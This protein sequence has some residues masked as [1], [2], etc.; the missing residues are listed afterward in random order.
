M[1]FTTNEPEVRDPTNTGDQA[2]VLDDFNRANTVE[3]NIGTPQIGAP[4]TLKGPGGVV[5]SSYGRILGNRVNTSSPSPTGSFYMFQYLTRA[6]KLMQCKATFDTAA[7]AGDEPS[8]TLACGPND[9]ATP[10][11]NIIHVR[12]G[13]SW[14]FI[15]TFINN[16]YTVRTS[17]QH[18]P[19]GLAKDT[20]H[21]F[22]VTFDP[23]NNT[24]K[25]YVN[26]T[27]YAT[28][29]NA[30]LAPLFGPQIFYQ[31]TYGQTDPATTL[32]VDDVLV[33]LPPS[34]TGY[35]DLPPDQISV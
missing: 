31:I 6:P 34:A 5:A 22:K 33:Q 4:W 3:P 11:K 1:T 12:F 24:V 15:D 26:G 14:V 30:L 20:P 16:V 2:A 23:V 7:G 27:E 21:T 29:S 32:H 17:V 8:L 18:T 35:T 9:L 10:F 25:A 19:A 28:Y 13:R